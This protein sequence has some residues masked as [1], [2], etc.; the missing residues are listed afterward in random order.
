MAETR[1]NDY[2]DFDE[3]ALV[4]TIASELSTIPSEYQVVLTI[5]TESGVVCCKDLKCILT[6]TP[7]L[8]NKAPHF[9]LFIKSSKEHEV[10]FAKTIS[11]D[12]LFSRRIL[13]SVTDALRVLVMYLKLPRLFAEHM[14]GRPVLKENA[15]TGMA[16]KVYS[17]RDV[18]DSSP[19]VSGNGTLVPGIVLPALSQNVQDFPLYT[20]PF[21]SWKD[22]TGLSILCWD[23]K[24]QEW[25]QFA[26]NNGEPRRVRL[27]DKAVEDLIEE[28]GI[29]NCHK[30]K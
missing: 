9:G 23:I 15:D 22:G 4:Q 19:I 7:M 24:K 17:W 27:S 3:A 12:V 25:A 11:G 21:M 26:V 20:L 10:Y 14:D 16:C 1:F 8:T 2:I 30:I 28:M 18:F 13:G 5:K 29:R 6:G